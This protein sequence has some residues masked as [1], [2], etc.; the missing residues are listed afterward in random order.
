MR[1]AVCAVV[2]SVLTMPV[3]ASD[4]ISAQSAAARGASKPVETTRVVVLNVRPAAEPKPALKFQ[5]L[6]TTLEQTPGNA[7]LIHHTACELVPAEGH[8]KLDEKVIKWIRAPLKD[9]PRKE[10]RQL[11][12][13][14]RQLLHQVELAAFREQCWWDI[15]IRIEGIRVML[16]ALGKQRFL[17]R[18]LAV[19]I[20]LHIAEGRCEQA[21]HDLKVG[22]S[23]A[24]H[25]ADAPTVIQSLVGTA[26]AQLM[27]ER[28]EELIRLPDCPNLYWALSHLPRPFID[29]QK[30][31]RY[32]RLWLF[33]SFPELLDPRKTQ[34][35]DKQWDQLAYRIADVFTGIQGTER[36]KEKRQ[37]IIAVQ[38]KTYPKAKRYLLDQGETPEKVAAMH[39][40][41]VLAIYFVDRMN[42]WW[43]ET[44][45]WFSLSY[46][47]AWEGHKKTE[48]ALEKAVTK[49][50]DGVPLT[51]LVPSLGRAYG[52]TTLI[53][54]RI[55]GLRCIEAIRRHAAE[56]GGKLP[57]SLKDIT[58]VPIPI[59]PIT[60]KP[61]RYKLEAGKGVLECAP[62][63]GFEPKHGTR[64]ELTISR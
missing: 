61:F 3:A 9:L 54:R 22:L 53:D 14:H 13:K 41:Q 19:R 26:V 29:F 36:D 48:A 7:A 18:L 47:E 49:D 42:Y 20:R 44:F 56:H 6:P 15:P 52:L 12:D 27:T 62:P 43:D 5:L 60:G 58:A 25:I 51:G 10:V 17:A 23:M 57:A 37:E 40:N 11:V 50:A 28:V 64:Y 2:V 4:A 63:P 16:P 39:V 24:R 34:L 32:E 38:S 21:I 8:D 55:A 31:L 59:D 33:T 35:T 30:G 1:Y 45:K 46:W